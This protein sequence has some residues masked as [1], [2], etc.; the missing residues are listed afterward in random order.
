M[1]YLRKRKSSSS[2][3]E[4]HLVQAHSRESYSEQMS[5]DPAIRLEFSETLAE[6]VRGS[7]GKQA[8]VVMLR[9]AGYSPAQVA[10]MLNTTISSVHGLHHRGRINGQR[11]LRAYAPSVMKEVT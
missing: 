3:D 9:A 11:I 1:D 5:I 7:I 10:Y 6:F 2:F 8:Q 4:S